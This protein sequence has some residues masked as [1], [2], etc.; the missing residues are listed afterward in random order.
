[1]FT[2]CSHYHILRQQNLTVQLE[3]LHIVLVKGIHKKV[4]P[5]VSRQLE[6][7]KTQPKT[8]NGRQVSLQRFSLSLCGPAA[9]VCVLVQ[10][11]RAAPSSEEDSAQIFICYCSSQCV[12]CA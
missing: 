6:D 12:T 9:G 4:L 8:W 10:L 2:C 11:Y 3:F 1:M 5:S 7:E